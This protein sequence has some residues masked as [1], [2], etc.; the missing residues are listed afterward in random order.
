MRW[1]QDAPHPTFKRK[2][3]RKSRSRTVSTKVGTQR[4]HHIVMGKGASKVPE[5]SKSC[6]HTWIPRSRGIKQRQ[7]GESAARRPNTLNHVKLYAPPIHMSKPIALGQHSGCTFNMQ[8]AKQRQNKKT[9]TPAVSLFYMPL[10]PSPS[11]NLS[12]QIP[13]YLSKSWWV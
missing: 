10:L 2:C 1:S 8:T 12:Q 9:S 4:N 11:S 13:R 7:M 3:S 5:L 6:I